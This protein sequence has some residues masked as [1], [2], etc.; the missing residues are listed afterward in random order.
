MGKLPAG[1]LQQAITF[2]ELCAV[3]SKPM[4]AMTIN[5]LTLI[6][7]TSLLLRVEDAAVRVGIDMEAFRADLD[8]GQEI[9]L[10]EGARAFMKG[11]DDHGER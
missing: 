4:L 9:V 10:S 7:I 6:N 11:S 3:V 5:R 1:C 2:A 8:A